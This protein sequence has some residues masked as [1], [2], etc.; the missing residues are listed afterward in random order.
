[1]K[2]QYVVLNVA[3][4]A[5]FAHA[6][7]PPLE[8]LTHANK[9]V[10]S[11]GYSCALK[12]DGTVWCW[13][14]NFDEPH[15]Y[16]IPIHGISTAIGLAAKG[17]HTCA[18]LRDGTVECWGSNTDGE[19]GNGEIGG[20]SAIPVFVHGAFYDDEHLTNALDIAVGGEHTCAQLSSGHM[21]CWGNNNYGQ[22]G[23]GTTTTHSWPVYASLPAS[24]TSIAA[25]N[26]HSCAVLS[27]HS[28]QCWGHN[29]HGQLGDGG[30]EPYSLPVYVKLAGGEVPVLA[31][32][33]SYDNNCIVLSNRS[34]KCW[35]LNEYGELGNGADDDGYEV[36]HSTPTTVVISTSPIQPLY[37][38]SD[39]AIGSVHACAKMDDGLGNTSLQCWGDNR[40]G[41]LGDGG[42]EERSD[43]STAVLANGNVSTPLSNILSVAAGG[44]TTCAVLADGTVRCWGDDGYGQLG[45]GFFGDLSAPIFPVR[46]AVDEIFADDFN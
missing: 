29:E 39:V 41:Q 16:A 12:D 3:L 42:S 24:A 1:M 40:R 21:V 6:G 43:V 18:L 23:D 33:N 22:L 2:L 37:P 11:F 9:V 19:L 34:V 8:T 5:G 44:Y 17:N 36:S 10:M 38:V 28:M 25:G 20:Y 45:T 30:S 15:N 32:G 46:E 7:N 14:S 31:E 26:E 35:G 27:T 4:A 13:G